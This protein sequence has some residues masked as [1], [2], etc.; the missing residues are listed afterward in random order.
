MAVMEGN[1]RICGE[2]DDECIH[3]N[4]YVNGSEGIWVC[5]SCRI[6]L[7][8]TARSMQSVAGRAIM[9]SKEK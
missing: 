7:T 9:N 8:N 2:H 3:L 1:C 4:L 5:L 6:D